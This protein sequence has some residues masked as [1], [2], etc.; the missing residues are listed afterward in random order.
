MME[1][2][3]QILK[4]RNGASFPLIIAITLCLIFI[5]TGISEYFRLMIVA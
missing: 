5:F 3:V 2:I 4:N 1:K